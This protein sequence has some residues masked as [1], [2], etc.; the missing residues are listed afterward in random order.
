M[1]KMSECRQAGVVRLRLHAQRT[2]PLLFHTVTN[3]AH[4]MVLGGL[5]CFSDPESCAMCRWDTR[6]ERVKEQEPGKYGPW[7]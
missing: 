3:V 6:A 5:V 1:Y 7:S 4:H 2:P